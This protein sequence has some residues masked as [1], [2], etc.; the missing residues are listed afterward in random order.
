MLSQKAKDSDESLVE[1]VTDYLLSTGQIGKEGLRSFKPAVCNRLDRNTSGL[2][3]A[4]KT[5]AGLQI[6]GEI[7]KNRSI[8]KYYLCLVK[9]SILKQQ[10]ISGFLIKD[11]RTNQVSVYSEEMEG[12]LP[13][14]TE[15]IPLDGN[16]SCTLLKVALI[17]GRSHQIRAH[18]AS[19]GHPIA[20]DPKYGDRRMNEEWKK[21]YRL[22][23][24]LLHS[25]Q[26]VLPELREPLSGL[27]GKC[28]TAPVPDDFRRALKG[29]GL[30]VEQKG[31]SG[32]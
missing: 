11:E 23:S 16:E 32:E 21:K 28:F 18:L 13:I 15:Y 2:V 4:G 6:M 24:Q 17:T 10:K 12:S 27:S 9:G 22:N 30:V 29:E 7:F 19:I 3:A 26:M 8:H 25:W 20:G 5:L 1:Y 14:E 31:G